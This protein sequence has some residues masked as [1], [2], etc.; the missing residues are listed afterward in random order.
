MKLVFILSAF[1]FCSVAFASSWK[2]S[3]YTD[4]SPYY[5]KLKKNGFKQRFRIKAEDC[6]QVVQSEILFKHSPTDKFFV[7]LNIF[8][9]SSAGGSGFSKIF[10]VVT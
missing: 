7:F 9:F 1:L 5:L 3:F 8:G 6:N 10:L 2:S 4:D